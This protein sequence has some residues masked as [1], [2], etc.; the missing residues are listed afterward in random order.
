MFVIAKDW[1]VG[2]TIARSAVSWLIRPS[3]P[4]RPFHGLQRLH[5]KA[6]IPSFCRLQDAKQLCTS[7]KL[8][9]FNRI[10]N[11]PLLCQS[12]GAQGTAALLP[13]A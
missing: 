10:A 6:S 2:A 7:A 1:M 5:S 9:G 8:L 3:I 12:A 13:L 11:E 4:N